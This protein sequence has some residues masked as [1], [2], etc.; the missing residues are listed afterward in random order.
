[1]TLTQTAYI[2]QIAPRASKK[3]TRPTE[4]GDLASVSE[5]SATELK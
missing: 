4:V 2:N 3:A 5:K 1:M